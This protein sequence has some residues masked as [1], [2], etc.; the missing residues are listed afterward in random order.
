MRALRHPQVA[1]ETHD[2]LDLG[3]VSLELDRYVKRPHLPPKLAEVV[4]RFARPILNRARRTSSHSQSWATADVTA[5][6]GLFVEGQMAR[7]LRPQD[8][9]SGCSSEPIDA[10]LH[11]WAREPWPRKLQP[12]LDGLEID[13]LDEGARLYLQRQLYIGS[14]FDQDRTGHVVMTL[15]CITESEGNEGALSEMNLRA[16]SSAIG[17][18]EDR[19]LGLIEAFDQ[20]PLLSVFEQM[21]ALEYFYVSE[22]Q[23]A[24]E[25]ILKHK[26]RRILPSPPPPPSKEELRDA[27][28]R[29]QEEARQAARAAIVRSI[30]KRIELGIQLAELR[31]ATPNNRRFGSIVRKQFDI[32]DSVFVGELQRAAG[33]YGGRQDITGKARNWHVLVALASPSLPSSARRQFEA[34]ILAGENVTAKTIAAKASRRTRK[35]GRQIKPAVNR[36]AT[37]ANHKKQR[38][39]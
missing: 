29:G 16:V 24:L 12:I 23:G 20:I 19:G 3:A 27:R 30:G 33:L 31:T 11:R 25:R 8:E 21:R 26:L 37:T 35:P 1:L 7:Q 13:A 36:R 34:K 28:R 6:K 5:P 10:S 38:H 9:D 39:Q 4:D 18:F 2:A 22:A 15:R 17:P 32:H 14:L